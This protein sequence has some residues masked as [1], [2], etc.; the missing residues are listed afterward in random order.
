[1]VDSLQWSIQTKRLGRRIWPPTSEKI[2]YE[3]PVNSNGV[4]SDI[5][6]EG[7]R[8]AQKTGQGSTLLYPGSV[9]IGIDLVRVQHM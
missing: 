2:G 1:M 6:L 8:V 9:G 4:L 5:V 3:N 7:E